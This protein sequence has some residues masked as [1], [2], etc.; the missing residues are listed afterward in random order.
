[1][2]E[3]DSERDQAEEQ[4]LEIELQR[5]QI[6]RRKRMARVRKRHVHRD[7]ALRRTGLEQALGSIEDAANEARSVGGSSPEEL[8]RDLRFRKVIMILAGVGVA[9]ALAYE[10]WRW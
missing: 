2:S 7:P 3:D 5:R 10:I 6:K 8:E 1:M 4:R 9:L